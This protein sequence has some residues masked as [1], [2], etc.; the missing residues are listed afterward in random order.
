MTFGVKSKMCM[1]VH[2]FEILPCFHETTVV[3][4]LEKSETGHLSPANVP[5]YFDPSYKSP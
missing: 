1:L 4:T 2:D 3:F 5:L